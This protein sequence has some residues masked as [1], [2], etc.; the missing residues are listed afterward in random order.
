MIKQKI[1]CKNHTANS[2]YLNTRIDWL[3][4]YLIEILI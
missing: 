4:F 3:K 1:N 2:P